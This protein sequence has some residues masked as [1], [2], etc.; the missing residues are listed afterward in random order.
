VNRSRSLPD[1]I[2]LLRKELKPIC[3]PQMEA[4]CFNLLRDQHP[5]GPAC[6]Y[7]KAPMTHLFTFFPHHYEVNEP[8]MMNRDNLFMDSLPF[9][10][11]FC[12]S[13]AKGLVI[14]PIRSAF[15]FGFAYRASFSHETGTTR[16]FF[17]GARAR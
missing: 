6:E 7:L 13:L 9:C 5:A 17:E 1:S 2:P 11:L 10:G 3:I 15:K 8:K 4:P 14:N 16:N 12:S